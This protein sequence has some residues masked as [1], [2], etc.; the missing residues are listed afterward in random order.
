MKTT[1]KD[2]FL[3]AGAM[4]ALY[5]SVFSFVGLMFEYINRAFPDPLAYYTDPYSGVIRFA[6]ASLVVL[7]PVFLILMNLIRRDIA[8]MPEKKDIWVRRWALTL[9]LFVAGATIVID[10][11]TL[12]NT[13]L[14]GDLTTRF[15]LKVAVVLLVAV[16][17]FLHFL[18]DLR[19]YW[20]TTP[21]RARMVGIGAGILIIAT[22]VGGF[23]IMGTP[24]QV[25]LY[26]FDSE[27]VND[28]QNIQYQIVNYWQQKQKLPVSL[29]DL[30]D[31]ISGYHIPTDAQNNTPYEYE[32]TGSLSFKVCAT[33]NAESQ[34][35]TGADLT[36]PTVPM[37]KGDISDSWWHEAGHTCFDRTID[38]ERY[39]PYT[40]PVGL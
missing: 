38:P 24:A 20:I 19:G 3:W 13:Y 32:A 36:R 33:F 1:P 14:G 21:G 30:A 4:L 15:G 5:I 23:F 37:G 7:F 8:L 31:P 2:F 17:V 27:K 40:K 16:V 34:Q 18:A 11:V 39:P 28:L 35:A 6:I 9:T 29:S 22:I 10:L 12:L 26:R 25:R